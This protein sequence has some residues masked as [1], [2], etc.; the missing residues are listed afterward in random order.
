[1]PDPTGTFTEIAR[2]LR[3]GGS[4]V[5]AC[6]TSDTPPPA[7]MDPDIYRIPTAA[8]LTAMLTAAGFHRVD[9]HTVDTAGYEL[10]L[11]AAH[12]ANDSA[13]A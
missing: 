5:L 4:L 2:V 1:M 6:R 7:W 11:F 13:A 8:D 3:P 12:L 10:H 9:H